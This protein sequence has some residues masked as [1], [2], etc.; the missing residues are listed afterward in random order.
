M[1][2]WDFSDLVSINHRCIVFVVHG[3]GEHS[4]RYDEL[5]SWLTME[6][7][8]AVVFALDHQ[9]HG[10]SEGERAHVEKFQHYVDDV[11]HFIDL[12]MEGQLPG[13]EG[14]SSTPFL[15]SLVSKDGKD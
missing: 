1:F 2:I 15:K 13:F 3:F 4:G 6:K 14:P 12:I 11:W 8:G 7:V 5:A 10:L 9:G